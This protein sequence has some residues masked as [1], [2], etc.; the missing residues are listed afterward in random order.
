MKFFGG[1]VL[2]F[3]TALSGGVLAQTPF[4]TLELPT[5]DL[6]FDSEDLFEQLTARLKRNPAV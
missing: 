3:L 6:P 1:A 5:G 2:A 4:T